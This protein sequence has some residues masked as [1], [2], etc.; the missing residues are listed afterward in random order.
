MTL[1][2]TL[3]LTMS[4]KTFDKNCANNTKNMGFDGKVDKG[5]EIHPRDIAQLQG[6]E[7][8][9]YCHTCLQKVTFR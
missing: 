1:L 8:M 5:Q 9:Q 3:V 7:F 4:T 2:Y 6:A